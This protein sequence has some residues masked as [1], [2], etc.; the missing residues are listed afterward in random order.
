MYCIGPS[1]PFRINVATYKAQ[2]LKKKEIS[3]AISR[4]K[5]DLSLFLWFLGVKDHSPK[6]L[7]NI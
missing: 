4:Q 7:L 6:N 5:I 2:N 3:A 1:E